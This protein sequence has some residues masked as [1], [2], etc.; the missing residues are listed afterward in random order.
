M[1]QLSPP[2]CAGSSNFGNFVYVATTAGNCI[3]AACPASFSQARCTRQAD[4]T[5]TFGTTPVDGGVIW[6]NVGVDAT[7]PSTAIFDPGLYYVDAQGLSFA[8]GSTARISTATGDG[9]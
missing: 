3:L 2:A 6:Q 4:G 9:I 1:I 7:S 5:C 8:G